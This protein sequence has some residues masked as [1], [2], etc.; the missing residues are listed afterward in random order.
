MQNGR[1]VQSNIYRNGRGVVAGAR[2]RSFVIDGN[3]W[4]GRHH[5]SAVFFAWLVLMLLVQ[6]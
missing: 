3:I 1:I 6:F 4:R 5:S 2:L